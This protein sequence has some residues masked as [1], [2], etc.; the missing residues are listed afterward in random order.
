MYKETGR[1]MPVT[2]FNGVE[3]AKSVLSEDAKFPA[4]K[5]E[6]VRQQGWKVVDLTSEKRVHLSD[7]LSKIPEREYNRLEEVVEALEAVA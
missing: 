5:A 2:Q 6:L 7:L 3:S 1:F 4:S